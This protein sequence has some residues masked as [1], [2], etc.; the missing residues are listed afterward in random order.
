MVAAAAVMVVSM[1]MMSLFSF[2]KRLRLLHRQE[3]DALPNICA[4][5]TQ[6]TQ[7][8][9]HAIAMRPLLSPAH[10]RSCNMQFPQKGLAP[11]FNGCVVQLRSS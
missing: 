5:R 10:T 2:Y 4:H 1:M 8:Q 3:D 9:L 6:L 11:N 7:L